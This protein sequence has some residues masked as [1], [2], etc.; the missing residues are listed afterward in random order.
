M[1]TSSNNLPISSP[2]YNNINNIKI[3]R[4]NNMSI[5][6]NIRAQ[7]AEHL[8]TSTPTL[9]EY[10]PSLTPQLLPTAV[11]PHV[12]SDNNVEDSIEL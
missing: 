2:I 11:F 6:S 1:C 9:L 8:C 12:L 7:I 4:N 3:A 5:L 10:L